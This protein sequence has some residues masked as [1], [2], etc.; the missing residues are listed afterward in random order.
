[1]IIDS[2]LRT[3][4]TTSAVS[5]VSCLDIMISLCCFQ[6][7]YSNTLLCCLVFMSLLSLFCS[8]RLVCPTLFPPFSF[9]SHE[10]PAFRL[11]LKNKSGVLRLASLALPLCLTNAIAN[12]RFRQLHKH[13]ILFHKRPAFCLFLKNKSESLLVYYYTLLLLPLPLLRLL[14]LPILLL[15]LRVLLLL[16][17]I[18]LL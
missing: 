5:I 1:M 10:L 18:F 11:C 3:S 15:L 14:V 12:V 2:S 4:T 8:P 7:P 9:H 6:L 17:L 13:F 16:L